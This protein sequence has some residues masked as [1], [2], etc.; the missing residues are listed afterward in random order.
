MAILLG[1]S[2]L[3]GWSSFGPVQPLEEVGLSDVHCVNE[4]FTLPSSRDSHEGMEGIM[5]VVAARP[6]GRGMQW[7]LTTFSCGMSWLSP[8]DMKDGRS[9]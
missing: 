1:N 4:D 5:G 6:V 2:T 9:V 3:G 7:E 8:F